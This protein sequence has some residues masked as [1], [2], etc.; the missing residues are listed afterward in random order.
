MSR[1]RARWSVM[2]VAFAAC[3][4][5]PKPVNEPISVG[6]YTVNIRGA[7][8]VSWNRG[9][10]IIVSDVPGLCDLATALACS[11]SGG[12]NPLH[13]SK[14]TDSAVVFALPDTTLR[15]YDASD[16]IVKFAASLSR[17]ESSAR[18]GHVTLVAYDPHGKATLDYDLEM[19]TGRTISGRVEAEICDVGETVR[20]WGGYTCATE[21]VKK[22]CADAPYEGSCWTVK[23]N[24]SCVGHTF[25]L[26]CDYFKPPFDHFI[27]E[28]CSC[29]DPNGA[30]STCTNK[31][32]AGVPCC[33]TTGP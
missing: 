8:A 30:E 15:R 20:P 23:Q 14:G 9:F 26:V 27:Q 21:V 13:P 29:V 12:F 4:P 17:F 22:V 28:S 31:Y 10:E 32:Y 24:C 11:P 33:P 25:S 19:D 18:S 7:M 16:V 5:S 3:G 6:I 1:V 2:V